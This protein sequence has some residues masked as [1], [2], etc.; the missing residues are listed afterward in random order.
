[1]NCRSCSNREAD[2]TFMGAPWCSRCK[3]EFLLA[4]HRSFLLDHAYRVQQ[5]A[6]AQFQVSMTVGFQSRQRK[7]RTEEPLPFIG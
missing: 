1:M 4:P 3:G 7:W 2:T 6:R 5:Q